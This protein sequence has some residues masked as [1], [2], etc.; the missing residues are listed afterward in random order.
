MSPVAAQVASLLNFH[1]IIPCSSTL[2]ALRLT[3]A[4]LF[5]FVSI[6]ALAIV[7]ILTRLLLLMYYCYDYCSYKANHDCETHRLRAFLRHH[8]AQ[9]RQGFRVFPKTRGRSGPW[10]MNYNIVGSTCVF[11]IYGSCHMGSVPPQALKLL[12]KPGNL[13]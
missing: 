13:Q 12:A 2:F 1:V 8:Q 4:M 10:N 6:L 3:S 11:S 7:T 9:S 5:I